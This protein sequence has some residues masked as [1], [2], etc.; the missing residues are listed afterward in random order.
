M[1]KQLFK[2]YVIRN[3]KFGVQGRDSLDESSLHDGNLQPASL[4]K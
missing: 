4:P 3:K 2:I 1:T